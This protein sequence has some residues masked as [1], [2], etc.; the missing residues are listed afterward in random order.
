MQLCALVVAI[1]L[2]VSSPGLAFTARGW[3]GWRKLAKFVF[4]AQKGIGYCP[5]LFFALFLPVLRNRYYQPPSS[6]F[7]SIHHGTE[8]KG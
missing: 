7:Y 6:A 5:M 4:I 1:L 8:S 2:P 3:L